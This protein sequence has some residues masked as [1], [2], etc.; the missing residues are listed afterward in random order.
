MYAPPRPPWRPHR[1]PD[2]HNGLAPTHAPLGAQGPQTAVQGHQEAAARPLGSSAGRQ[3]PP[4]P[5]GARPPGVC[6]PRGRRRHPHQR[7]RAASSP[8]PRPWQAVPGGWG[9]G[10]G[11]CA[12]TAAQFRHLSDLPQGKKRSSRDPVGACNPPWSRSGGPGGG[13]E[14]R[15]RCRHPPGGPRSTMT[16]P[17]EP[18]EGSPRPSV[19]PTSRSRGVGPL[20]QGG[21]DGVVERSGRPCTPQNP[22][23]GPSD[24]PGSGW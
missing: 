14:G 10:R 8:L 15:I 4:Q 19:P 3:G 23:P 11:A 24:T 22:P 7:H 1:P 17:L 13:Q 6:P 5:P 16:C 9:T 21:E 2:A 12:A 18:P 20:R